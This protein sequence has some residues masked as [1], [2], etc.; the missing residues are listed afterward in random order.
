M[1]I[2]KSIENGAINTTV[3]S[4]LILKT[5]CQDIELGIYDYVRAIDNVCSDWMRNL[6]VK[7]LLAVI[8]PNLDLG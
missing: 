3:L 4:H 7:L 6:I 5:L 2:T 1:K 8:S